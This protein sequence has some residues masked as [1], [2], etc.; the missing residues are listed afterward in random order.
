MIREA[1]F[2]RR[3]HAQRLMDAAEVVVCK[4]QCDSCSKVLPLFRERIGE[5]IQPAMEAGLI[6]RFWRSTCDVQM[7]S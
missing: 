5:P 4:M 3:R 1:S 7:C 6:V 2:H